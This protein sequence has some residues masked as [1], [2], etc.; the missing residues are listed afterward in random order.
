[1]DS[2]QRKEHPIQLPKPEHNGPALL[3][4]ASSGD[5]WLRATADQ[6]SSTTPLRFEV[7][8]QI[9]GLLVSKQKAQK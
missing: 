8:Y 6:T 2:E 1:M 4:E 3:G 5:P 9:V 7:E